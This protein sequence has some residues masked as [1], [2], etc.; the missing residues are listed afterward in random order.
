VP[1]LIALT[2]SHPDE[3]APWYG[4]YDAQLDRTLMF[5][6]HEAVDHPAAVVLAV[7][8]VGLEVAQGLF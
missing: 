3:A 4:A 5:A 1:G 7:S 2:K 6:E 8:S